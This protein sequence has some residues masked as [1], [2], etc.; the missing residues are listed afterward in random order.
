[1]S[2]PTAG[3]VHVLPVLFAQRANLRDRRLQALGVARHAAVVPHDLA[4][5]A[6]EGI[7]RALALDGEQ[8]LGPLLHAGDSVLDLGVRCVDLGEF[9]ASRDS[10]R[11]CRE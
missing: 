1:M 8:L 6:M 9:V 11:Q 3:T 7:D 10:C 5:L 4:E 2:S